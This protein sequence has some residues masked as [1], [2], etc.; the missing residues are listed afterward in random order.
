MASGTGK[1]Q[2]GLS[3]LFWLTTICAALLSF[4]VTAP[5]V[6]V[7]VA[8]MIVAILAIMA[9][10]I[11]WGILSIAVADVICRIVERITRGR[12]AAPGECCIV[13]SEQ[14]AEAMPEKR[15]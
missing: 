10:A 4:A 8:C 3:D 12:R 14:R 5:V 6:F 11:V 1:W 7:A 2:F 9:F 13:A 15:A